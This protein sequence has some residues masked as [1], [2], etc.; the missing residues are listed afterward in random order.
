[1]ER[2]RGVDRR[3]QTS[4]PSDEK[5][6]RRV[7]LEFDEDKEIRTYKE[8]RQEKEETP[9]PKKSSSTNPSHRPMKTYSLDV[10]TYPNKKLTGR[11]GMVGNVLKRIVGILKKPKD[12]R[13][14]KEFGEMPMLWGTSKKRKGKNGG[15][16]NGERRF[17]DRRI[18]T[19]FREGIDRYATGA[20]IAA[21]V[22][23]AGTAAGVYS[24][25]N[26][27]KNNGKVE[28]APDYTKGGTLKLRQL[29]PDE[30]RD[31]FH[32]NT[33]RIKKSQKTSIPQST[34]VKGMKRVKDQIKAA[35]KKSNYHYQEGTETGFSGGAFGTAESRAK[36][37]AISKKVGK[38]ATALRKFTE[39]DKKFR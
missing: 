30:I 19:D 18:N 31:R 32:T 14:S 26:K 36:H 3:W 2:R 13:A 12:R 7:V 37:R 27:D 10:R 6:E 17:E 1:M 5:K 25:K 34:Y 16:G 8:R 4:F 11:L 29:T 15:P 39:R 21:P 38:K 28:A 35:V 23:A 20:K 33:E 22:I 9:S 24:R